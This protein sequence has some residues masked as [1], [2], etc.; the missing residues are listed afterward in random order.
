MRK[1]S[2]TFTALLT[3]LLASL[4]LGAVSAGAAAGGAVRLDA[5]PP[6][7]RGA[8]IEGP[9]PD[10]EVLNLY[11]GLEPRDP[12]AL[13]RFAT[14]VS[15]PGSPSF[16]E[17]LTVPEF[18]QRFGAPAAQ[19]AAVGTA[20]ERR[21]LEVGEPGRNGLSLPVSATV[22]EAEDAFGLSV[23]EVELQSGQVA[24]RN[25]R[26]PALPAAVAPYIEAV[27]G[28]DDVTE[29]QRQSHSL[30]AAPLAAGSAS[31]PLTMGI[32]TGGPQPCKAALEA[33]VKE[34]GGYTADQIA[35]TY[36]FSDFY[37]AG[38]FGAGHKIALLEFEPYLPSDIETYQ[39]CYGTDVEITNVDVN[40]GPG[41]YAGSDGESALDIEQLIGLA[42]GAEIVVYQGPNEG[43][44]PVFAAYVE[45]NIAK[46]MSSS[47]GICE[48]QAGKA[49][50]SVM[51]TL[52]Q[53]AAAQG[54]SF[55]V[56]AGDAG[57]T[58]CWT[59]KD[60]DEDLA[61]DTPGSQPFA[62]DV[63]GTRIEQPTVPP[64]EFLWNDKVLN[65]AGGGGVSEHFPMPAYQA[66]AAPGVGVISPL[67]T[68]L[69]CGFAGYCRQV[70]DVSANAS[71]G[72]GYIVFSEKE[73]QLTG[74]T[75][76][77]A[78]L[79]AALATLTNAS[80]ACGGHTIGF[81]NPALYGIAATGYAENFHDITGARP[82]GFTSNNMFSDGEPFPVGPN[83]D[84][85]TGLGSPNSPVLANSLC[86]LANPAVTRP[87]APATVSAPPKAAAPA[88]DPRLVK[89]A[90]AG[91]SGG[92]PKLTF[93]LAARG[94][95][96]LRWVSVKLPAGI[97]LGAKP[98][99][100]RGVAA[101]AGKEPL[102]I[103]AS[104]KGRT[105]RIQLTEPSPA[106]RFRLTVPALSLTPALE[107]LT[108]GQRPP[109]LRVVVTVGEEGSL[110]ARYPLSLG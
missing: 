21:G 78:P 81:A 8:T 46:V 15:T 85:A 66:E 93:S 97:A 39:E 70:P 13:E 41:P 48:K 53:E 3:G 67:S 91:V 59:E 50:M 82:G 9:A 11:I 55:F 37:A 25:D 31:P 42:P 60:K 104:G 77:A 92:R 90:L 51:D 107:E 23:Q 52:L 73:W 14:T 62:T 95:S 1:L 110:G 10:G 16:G 109:A 105:L 35:N 22:A 79:W 58:D 103:K 57:S 100:E 20:L 106:A 32:P 18:A 71:P 45:Q 5:P 83:Y 89:A 27:L 33:Q 4:T 43:E 80:A 84:M 54:Q 64:V 24:L 108:R 87:A 6:L 72:T 2:V 68:G 56:A 61:V 86:E 101:F 44:A 17:Y 34:G 63:G 94:G 7:P 40:G 36:R 38:N 19:I 76:A 69:T 88:A 96:A 99:L 26:A 98:E 28:L 47:W 75:S 12:G 65:G 74:G 29:S 102:A 49:E 30:D